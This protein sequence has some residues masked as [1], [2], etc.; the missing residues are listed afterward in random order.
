M[1][2]E[3]RAPCRTAVLIPCHNEGAAIAAVV[4]TFRDALP[5]ADIYVFDNNST[6]DT[7]RRAIEAG[8][9]VRKEIRQGKGYVVRRMF[10]DVEADV[11][12]LVDGDGTY[13]APSAPAMIRTLLDERLD[14]VVGCRMEQKKAAYRK[15]HRFGNKL[16][17]GSV[18]A[19]FGRA[20]TD[21]L[22]GYR[23]FSR[24][25]VKSFPLFSSGF[26]IET[27]MC[28]HALQLR[29]PT[30]EVM[31][32]YGSRT[33]GSASKLRTYHDGARILL[34]ILRLL[35]LERPRLLFGTLFIAL[36]GLSLV[37][38]VPIFLT[39]L[40]TGLVPR[41]PTALLSTGLMLLAF[42]LLGFGYLLDSMTRA[43]LEAKLLAYL[44]QP[45]VPGGR[46]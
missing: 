1:S 5:D 34:M 44:A 14:M 35:M 12:V 41:F 2:I 24:R 46:S 19:L 32:P 9:L 42:F 18:A 23:V 38:S 13:H 6:D 16:L 8:A 7:V 43:R 30:G 20:F 10:A 27:E 26:E 15:G 37:L 39:Y 21:M 4:R 28:V 17:T 33:E 31:T 22:S 45:P 11:Y 40:E 25:Y 36:A 3:A 29:L